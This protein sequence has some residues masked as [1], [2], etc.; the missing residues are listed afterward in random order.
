VNRA[1]TASAGRQAPRGEERFYKREFWQTENLKFVTPHFRLVKVARIVRQIALGRRCDL[2]DVGCGPAALSRLMPAN[3]RY[4]GIDIAIQEPAANLIE[5]DFLDE[6][7]SFRG[8]SFDLIVSQGVFEYVGRFQSRQLKEISDL[9]RDG[10]I[11]VVT[12]TNYAH[13]QKAPYWA[14]NNIRQPA[15]FRRE[16]EQYFRVEKCFPSSYN[17]KQLHPSCTLIRWLQARLDVTIPVIST[18]FA[19]DYIY[20][21]SVRT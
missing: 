1:A 21:C 9:L 14:H 3:V 13:R 12:Y 10:G 2:L 5:M 8:Q 17:W 18:L 11:F 4:H 6:R 15:E 7:I 20:I 16:L 19:V